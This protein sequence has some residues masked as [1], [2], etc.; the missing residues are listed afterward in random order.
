MRIRKNC[1]R[2]SR[3]TTVV[4]TALALAALGLAMSSTAEAQEKG[5]GLGAPIEGT[6]IVQVHRVTQNVTFTA[7]QS[8]TAGGVT[9]ATG[10]LDRNPLPAISPL[11]GTWQRVGGNNYATSLCF[12]I[13]DDAGD[14]LAMLQNYEVFHLNADHELVGTGDAYLC[15]TNGENCVKVES[16]TFTGKRLNAQHS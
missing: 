1:M 5:T 15:D 16:L 3:S 14:A 10:T 11:Y 8:F 7:L 12:F 4:A 2:K 6:W 13:F 9:L